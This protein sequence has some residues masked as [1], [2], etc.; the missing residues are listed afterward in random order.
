MSMQPLKI[1]NV[2]IPAWLIIWTTVVGISLF[3]IIFNDW[4]IVRLIDYISDKIK[5]HTGK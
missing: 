4:T 5:E 3:L 1:G 2:S